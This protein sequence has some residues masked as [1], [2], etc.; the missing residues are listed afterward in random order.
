L[1][2][3]YRLGHGRRRANA[4]RRTVQ[5][6]DHQPGCHRN[7]PLPSFAFVVV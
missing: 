2:E 7:H 3:P 4:V 6:C 5:R 1:V